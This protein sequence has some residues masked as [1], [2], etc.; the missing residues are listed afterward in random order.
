VEQED[1]VELVL[2]PAV[3]HALAVVTAVH[4]GQ[5]HRPTPCTEWTV[6]AVLAHLVDSFTCLTTALNFGAVPIAAE[7]VSSYAVPD[8]AS[9]RSAGHS[10][11]AAARRGRAPRIIRVAD[12]EVHRDELVLVG[13]V[14]AA[15]HGWD[16]DQGTRRARPI[17]DELAARLLDA[18][19]RIVNRHT[20]GDSFAPPVLVS[21]DRPPADR[22]LA[23]LGRDPVRSFGRT[24]P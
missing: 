13:A 16:I 22:L 3:E 19:P 21:S 12:R 20:R 9:L 2:V 6:G 18:L 17:A 23:A 10:L 14:E 24:D 15:V 1:A 5:L 4:P 11:V 8:A 7:D